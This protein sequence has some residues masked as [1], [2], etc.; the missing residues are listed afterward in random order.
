MALLRKKMVMVPYKVTL[1][2]EQPL[3]DRMAKLEKLAAEHGFEFNL[4]AG[5]VDSLVM[6]VSRA[7][8]FMQKA[9]RGG[10]EAS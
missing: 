10:G 2:V 3:S 4:E 5:L 9:L 6:Q 7:E 8:S 1:Q